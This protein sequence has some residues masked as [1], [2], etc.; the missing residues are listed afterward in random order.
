MKKYFKNKDMVKRLKRSNLKFLSMNFVF[1]Q[2]KRFVQDFAVFYNYWMPPDKFKYA[3]FTPSM[4][5]VIRHLKRRNKTQTFCYKKMRYKNWMRFKE[6][7]N[8]FKNIII[9]ESVCC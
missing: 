6:N 1:L 9:D 3:T 4:N 8:Y 7:S 5:K 2:L